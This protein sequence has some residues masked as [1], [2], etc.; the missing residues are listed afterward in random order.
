AVPRGIVAVCGFAGV[1]VYRRASRR[2]REPRRPALQSDRTVAAPRGA[3]REVLRDVFAVR[4]APP[5]L[6]P[7]TAKQRIVFWV[8]AVVCA[9]TRFMA[10]AR[11]LWDWDEAL[12]CLGM[13]SYDVTNHHPHP[14]GFPVYIFLAKIMRFF[15][16]D[17]FRALQSVNLIAGVL[18][19][20]AVYLL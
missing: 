2:A 3:R 11:T 1:A 20:P 7:A 8:V 10:M 9:A 15:T 16:H 6:E 13:R 19:F 18:L 4:V 14:P 12:F 17:D 5:E